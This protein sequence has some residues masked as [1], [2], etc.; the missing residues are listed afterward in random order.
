MME[1]KQ[2]RIPQPKP[3]ATHRTFS[4]L[5]SMAAV[6][7]PWHFSVAA[8]DDMAGSVDSGEATSIRKNPHSAQD[9]VRYAR[10][11]LPGGR[12][13]QVFMGMNASR[14]ATGGRVDSRA[15]WVPP[16]RTREPSA[17]VPPP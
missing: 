2:T 13:G 16:V 12:L 4:D 15:A 6:R 14:S 10:G 9:E 7:L 8:S 17:R 11:E 5:V 3:L 1:R